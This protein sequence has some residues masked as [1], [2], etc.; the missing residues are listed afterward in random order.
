M[1]AAQSTAAVA[2]ALEQAERSSGHFPEQFR[3]V[4]PTLSAERGLYLLDIAD[5]SGDTRTMPVGPPLARRRHVDFLLVCSCAC[6]GS[7]RS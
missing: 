2:L 5:G 1:A 6:P 7:D 3:I 4:D